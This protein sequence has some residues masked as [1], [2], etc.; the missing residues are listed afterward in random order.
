MEEFEILGNSLDES[1]KPES[2]LSNYLPQDVYLPFAL[3]E[4]DFQI[5]LLIAL[6]M[7]LTI[8]LIGIHLAWKKYGES[9]STIYSGWWFLIFL[10]DGQKATHSQQLLVPNFILNSTLPYP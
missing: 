9:L 10:I 4:L 1:P 2:I 3:P 5:K 7:W 8:N 6:L